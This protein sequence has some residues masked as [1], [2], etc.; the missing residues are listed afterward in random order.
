MSTHLN[1]RDVTQI[2]K[3][4]GMFRSVSGT[5]NISGDESFSFEDVTGHIG[6]VKSGSL[7]VQK[8]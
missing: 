1:T 5:I 4:N 3:S 7:I 2:F 6:K 8:N